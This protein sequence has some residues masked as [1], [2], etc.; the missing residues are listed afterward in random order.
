MTPQ[1]LMIILWK[2]RKI[3]VIKA[4]QEKILELREQFEAEMKKSTEDFKGIQTFFDKTLYL[5]TM[6]RKQ[7]EIAEKFKEEKAAIENENLQMMEIIKARNIKSP[8]FYGDY[9]SF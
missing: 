3:L 1:I 4:S 6:D 5:I 8:W 7:L 9:K 2:E